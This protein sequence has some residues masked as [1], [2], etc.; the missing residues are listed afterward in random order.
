MLRH[1]ARD[2]L[3]FLL[4]FVAGQLGLALAVEH[5][6]PDVRDPEYTLKEERLRR[7]RRDKPDHKLV[8]MLGSSRG[9]LGFRAALLSEL[10]DRDRVLVFNAAL[11]GGGP[12][13]DLVCLRRL[14]AAGLRP[15]LL[16]IDVVPL[17]FNQPDGLALEERILNG[18]RLRHSELAAMRPYW[19]EPG[20]HDR[21]WWKA[22]LLPGVLQQAELRE[23]VGLDELSLEA[24]SDALDRLIDSHGWYPRY[25]G[26]DPPRQQAATAAALRQY[27]PFATAFRLAP[28]PVQALNDLLAACHSERIPVVLV[29]MP[30]APAFRSLYSAEV[31]AGVDAFLQSVGRE[32]RVPVV[33]ARDWSPDEEFW[34]GHHL[35]PPAAWKVTLRLGGDVLLPLL[36]TQARPLGA[37]IQP[38]PQG[39]GLG[40]E[41]GQTRVT[42]RR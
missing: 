33:D 26:P 39:A 12:V 7:L 38:R 5:A 42:Q 29:V 3:W 18:N 14:L 4:A 2:L 24:P 28:R 17:H 23:Y 11:S 36:P 16:F 32:W 30:E 1:P 10:L 27:A 6:L 13:L 40:R 37:G 9:S 8:V 31:R 19:D 35:L 21:Q 41:T 20:R 15:D 22:R 34:D 25:P